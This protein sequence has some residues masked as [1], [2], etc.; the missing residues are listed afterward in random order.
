VVLSVGSAVSDHASYA[1][2]GTH[3]R[4]ADS[5]AGYQERFGAQSLVAC[6]DATSVPVHRFA[7]SGVL[8]TLSR[9]HKARAIAVAL[10]L[11]ATPIGAAAQQDD[12]LPWLTTTVGYGQGV[13]VYGVGALWHPPWGAEALARHG[14][15][16][17]L[18]VDVMRLQG[19]PHATGNH[20]LWNGNVTPYLRWRP[21]EGPWR[22]TF[23]EA[24]VG[25]QLLSDSTISG[26]SGYAHNF[27]MR[28]QFGERIAAGVSFG[29]RGRYEIA[30]FFQHVSNA[31]IKEPNDGLTY[32]GVT[33]RLA[34]E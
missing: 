11:S 5:T 31:K 19:D 6:R 13:A 14:L 25:I 28:L 33:L 1:P 8:V 10:L 4:G 16:L 9:L 23:V 2:E 29:P 7:R 15:D 27:G 3:Y 17:R 18:G 32:W 30:P 21:A 22:S 20:F 24:G 26:S 34:L 12:T